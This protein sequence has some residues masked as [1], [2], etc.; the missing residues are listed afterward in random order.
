MS[1]ESFIPTVWAAEL[2]KNLYDSHVF[3]KEGLCNRDYEGEIKGMGS[4]VRINS[5]G[6]ISTKAF[7]RNTD[8]DAP[9]TVNMADMQLLIDQ[10]RYFHFFIDNVDAKQA[11]ASFRADAMREAADS[12][13]DDIDTFLSTLIN[14]AVDGTANDLTNGTPITIGQGAGEKDFYPYVVQL[15][16]ILDENNTPATGRWLVA[17]AFAEAQMRLDDRFVGFGTPTTRDALRGD[18]VFRAGGFTIYKSNR[19]PAGAGASK[20]VLGGYRGAVSFAEQIEEMSAYKPE[21]R[22]GDAIK[23]LHI[24]GGKVTR[25]AN[26]V[27]MEVVEGEY[28]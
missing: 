4:S 3:A 25:P 24:Y 11:R 17:P 1:V 12:V 13:A 19:L 18:P 6:P 10:G 21:R 22:F 15:G 26:L 5:V 14:A 20:V 27:A 7:T 9:D 2:L 28:A 16:K 8:I 23:E